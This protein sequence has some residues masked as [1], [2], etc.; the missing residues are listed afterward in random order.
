MYIRN[1]TINDAD[2][3]RTIL[4]EAILETTATFDIE[5]K[6]I[7]DIVDWIKKH[8]DRFILYV[9]EIDKETVG[10]GALS[11]FS[12]R[13]GYNDMAELSIY[14]NKKFH[15]KGIGKELVKHALSK[16]SEVKFHTIVA[17]V[18]GGNQASIKMLA[19]FG[20]Q[21]QGKM[22]EVGIKFGK[23]WNLEIWQTFLKA[24]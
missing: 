13:K 21:F 12:E 6:S 15:K 1:A 8:D 5:I 19:P 16:A 9:A 7:E 24:K 23:R 11:K 17:F 22:K 20:F 2:A 10:L 4:N 18:T 3:I 14:V